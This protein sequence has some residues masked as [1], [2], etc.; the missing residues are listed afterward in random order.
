MKQ[1]ADRAFDIVK[2]EH[3]PLFERKLG[4]HNTMIKILTIYILKKCKRIL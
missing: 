3:N 4:K 1:D 2:S